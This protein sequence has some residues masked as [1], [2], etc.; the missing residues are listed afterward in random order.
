M[1]I[2]DLSFMSLVLYVY[3]VIRT[4]FISL[5]FMFVWCAVSVIGRLAVDLVC[6]YRLN[7]IELLFLRRLKGNNNRGVEKTTFFLFSFPVALA[8]SFTRFLDHTQRRITVGRIPL[9][10]WSAQS[11]RHLPDNTHTHNKQTSMLPVG[12]EPTIS[13]GE[14]P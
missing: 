10:E 7:W 14:R 8:S 9:D 4:M 6:L 2:Y 5:S 13:E 12:F 3:V 11:Q 1:L